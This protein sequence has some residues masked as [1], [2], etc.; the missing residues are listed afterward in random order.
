MERGPKLFRRLGPMEYLKYATNQIK[1]EIKIGVET[2]FLYN[3]TQ[4]GI[5]IHKIC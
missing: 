3:Y 5:F 2:H 1:Q 4:V